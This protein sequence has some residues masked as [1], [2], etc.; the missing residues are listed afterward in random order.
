MTETREAGGKAE[1]VLTENPGHKAEGELRG[2]EREEPRRGIQ[3][4][5]DIVL[6]KV[7]VQIFVVVVD[8][9]HQLVQPHLV[10]HTQ[11]T[12]SVRGSDNTWVGG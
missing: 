5:R 12:L 10:T 11:V 6:L 3:R 9:T 7:V 4:G 1:C 2:E 8:Q